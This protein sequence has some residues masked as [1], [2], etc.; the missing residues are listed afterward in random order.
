MLEIGNIENRFVIYV[1]IFLSILSI[2]VI[3]TLT[4]DEISFSIF[5][6]VPLGALS[7]YRGSNKLTV[8]LF[9]F[10]AALLWFYSDFITREYTNI[11]YPIWNAFTRLII[12]ISIGSLLI[13][14][15]EKDHKLKQVNEKLMKLNDEKNKFI[16]IAAHDLRSPVIGI[17]SY[18]HMLLADNTDKIDPEVMESLQYIHKSSNSI[19]KVIN[20]LLDV[21]VI[22]SGTLVLKR[23]PLDYTAFIKER[24]STIQM[25]AKNKELSISIH[26]CLN[27]I[28]IPVDPHY[29]SEIVDNLLTNAIKF[30]PGGGKI[31]INLSLTDNQRVLTEVTDNGKGIAEEEQSKLFNYFQKT[32]TKPTGDEVTTGLGLAIVKH[33]VNLHGGEVGVRSKL[34]EGSTFYYT[35]PLS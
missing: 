28:L 34:N 13:Y 14:L 25:R 26:S 32:S 2:G 10:F 23:E 1:I 6:L 11:Y 5:Y 7:L 21:S 24:I 17:S 18:T 22:E 8:I 35:L 15:R 30:T 31:S 3:D 9:A 12:F 4:E 20:D 19:L 16:G 29:M 33:L 27:G